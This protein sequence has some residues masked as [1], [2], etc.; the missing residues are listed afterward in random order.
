[1][2]RILRGIMKYRRT[3]RKTMV[4]QFQQVRDS[5]V[6]SLLKQNYIFMSLSYLANAT[7][8]DVRQ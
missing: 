8:S 1:M 3:D 5:P 4:E 2:E 7:S 6:V